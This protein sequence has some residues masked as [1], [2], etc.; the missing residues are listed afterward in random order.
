M[1]K[2]GITA[3]I[4]A[5]EFNMLKQMEEDIINKKNFVACFD[6]LSHMTQVIKY[7]EQFETL[8]NFKIY[9][10]K[11]NY[12]L[13][14]CE[15][16]TDKYV[17]YTPTIIYGIS[18][19]IKEVDVFCFVKKSH[20]NSFQ[21]YQM[22]NRSRKLNKV[23]I[24]C[25]LN[26]KKI[27]Y[28]SIDDVRDEYFMFEN[29]LNSLL[30]SGYKLTDEEKECYQLMYFYDKYF[31]SII[32]SDI[33]IYLLRILLLLGYNVIFNNNLEEKLFGDC[34]N[35]PKEI[36][37]KILEIFQIKKEDLNEFQKEL[38]SSDAKL[39]KH[40][41]LRHYYK[42]NLN[43]KLKENIYKS[44]FTESINCRFTKIKMSNLLIEEL[45]FSSLDD[46]NNLNQNIY[47]KFIKKFKSDWVN[48]NFETI[49]KIFNLEKNKYDTKSYYSMYIL[50]FALLKHLYGCD[51]F[52][53]MRIR[54][55]ENRYYLYVID[56]NILSEHIKL[57]K[58]IDSGSDVFRKIEKFPD[59]SEDD[60]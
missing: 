54:F 49:I 51:L 45:G 13:I 1:N 32:K 14:N 16:W 59:D 27:K 20:L 44:L 25:N 28:K 15:E 55:K 53:K 8:E 21:I 52:K 18:Y 34:D 22:I 42:S 9:S 2:I 37:E 11:V 57:F 26:T 58:L 31:D 23:H 30:E 56:S 43:L 38:M 41:N 36:K 17:F 40:F 33:Y 47:K 7:L 10:S 24:Y 4:Y 29:K 6:S 50:M 35:E 46:F 39:E 12:S 60:I 5:C 48:D 3:E 19:D